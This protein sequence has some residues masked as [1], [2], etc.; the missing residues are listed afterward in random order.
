MGT[1]SLIARQ[2]GPDAYRTIFCK[3]EGHLECQGAMLLEHFNTPEQ[4]DEILDL[5]DLYLLQPR[6]HPEPGSIHNFLEPQEGVTVSYGRDLDDHVVPAQIHT[7]IK[8]EQECDMIEFLYV[9]DQEGTWKYA[10]CSYLSE[11]LRDVKADLKAL[12]D[13]IDIIKPPPEDLL[14]EDFYGMEMDGM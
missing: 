10:Q 5:G 1:R 4:V 13:G 11:G 14:E 3:L 9:F 8:L 6:L 7:W 2:I 12:E